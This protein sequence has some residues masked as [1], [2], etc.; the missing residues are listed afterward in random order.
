MLLYVSSLLWHAWCF[1]STSGPLEEAG[2]AVSE[3]IEEGEATPFAVARGRQT[4]IIK[5]RGI[6]HV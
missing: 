5:A 2:I 4:V 1:F 3:S 6:N